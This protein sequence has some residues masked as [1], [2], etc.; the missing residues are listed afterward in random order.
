MQRTILVLFAHP[1]IHRSEAN[2]PLLQL[3]R[4]LD[5]V[6][7]VDL[8]AE[9]PTFEIDIDREQHRLRQHDVVIFMHPLYWYSTPAI[10]KEW[11]DLVLEHGFAYGAGGT[12]LKGKLFLSVTTAGAAQQAYTA[13]GFNHFSLRELL[14]PLEQTAEICGMHYL[15]PFVL[16][17]ARTATD[18]N[19]LQPHLAHWRQLLE[20]LRSR[21]LDIEQARTA[22]SLNDVLTL[23]GEGAQ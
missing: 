19:R 20:S 11:Q 14:R 5:G 12:A 4:Q 15:P 16:Y 17:G 18:E 6:T 10:L 7:V 1:S 21:S 8:Y 3:A 22:D 23:G 9:Y 13:E 2:A